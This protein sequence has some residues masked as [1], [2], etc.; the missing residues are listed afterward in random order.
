MS[1]RITL[2]K[3]SRAHIDDAPGLD[4]EV[5]ATEEAPPTDCHK[6]EPFNDFM[7]RHRAFYTAQA[8]PLADAL[9]KTLPG[10]T[11]DALLVELLDHKRSIYRVL[12][13]PP[14]MLTTESTTVSAPFEQ[15]RDRAKRIVVGSVVDVH[16][17][18]SDGG[19]SGPVDFHGTVNFIDTESNCRYSER[20]VRV[21]NAH[22]EPCWSTLAHCALA[23][24]E[25][26]G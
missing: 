11:I 22:G 13:D 16:R 1:I 7:S 4:L 5:R 17:F 3:A 8:K 2:Y 24:T 12:H 23:E 21:E 26:P 9:L 14:R 25:P 20:R 6:D 19:P 10:G 15:L 18:E